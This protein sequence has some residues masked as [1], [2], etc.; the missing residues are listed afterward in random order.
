MVM[1]EQGERA[2]V[3]VIGVSIPRS[4]HN[5]AVRLL[6]AAIPDD[7]FYCEYYGVPGCCQA[8]PCARR[9]T[10]P[11]TF[12]KSHDFDL[13]LPTDLPG[14]HY[15]AMYR[16][17][18]PAILSNREL[19][20]EEYGDEVASNRDEYAV[21]LGRNAE[22]Y[23]TFYERWIRTFAPNKTVVDYDE[24]AARPGEVIQRLLERIGR[25]ADATAVEQA[26]IAT[27]P[28]GGLFGERPYVP[29][30]IETSTYLDR[31][32]I[33]RFESIV[34]YHLPRLESRR[35]LE[36]IEFH[37]TVTWL[38]FAA[39]RASRSGD[40]A[41]ARQHFQAATELEPE[42]ASLRYEHA[43]VLL[44]ED[45][46]LEAQR[47]LT[48]AA[49]RFPTHRPILDALATA[50]LAA[51]DATSA[52]APM[53]ALAAATPT[54]VHQLRLVLATTHAGD[55]HAGSELLEQVARERPDDAAAWRL[56]AEIW[57]TRGNVQQALAALDTAVRLAPLQGDLYV[58]RG[59]ILRDAGQPGAAAV[60]LREALAIDA[61][62]PR[63][64]KALIG[65]YLASGDRPGARRA[66]DEARG[67]FPFDTDF[68]TMLGEVARQRERQPD[69][70]PR[71]RVTI[72]GRPMTSAG[73]RR[74]GTTP[75]T[76]RG[77]R[78]QPGGSVSSAPGDVAH[79][80]VQ[81]SQ[82]RVALGAAERRQS[83]T[84]VTKQRQL[85]AAW[86]EATRLSGSLHEL[87]A[88][89]K[90]QALELQDAWR[91]AHLGWDRAHAGWEQAQS[92]A[93]ELQRMGQAAEAAWEQARLL[94]RELRA[95]G[96]RQA[97]TAA[98]GE[99]HEMMRLR[100]TTAL[101]Q[102]PALLA[103]ACD[104]SATVAEV[105]A[106]FLLGFVALQNDLAQ[107]LGMDVSKALDAAD[108]EVRSLL[109]RFIDPIAADA[110]TGAASDEGVA[111]STTDDS[112]A[113]AEGSRHA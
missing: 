37:S 69:A 27:T 66:I 45:R 80:Q 5:F 64:W 84:E 54:L 110:V 112:D 77:R 61:G 36:P 10:Q 16:S 25:T 100:L 59:Q 86:D 13:N 29:R 95:N 56:M 65:A 15:L 74:P 6:Q 2:P 91:E 92:V 93:D 17:P 50:S 38:V 40:L 89:F 103:R 107:D 73:R 83:E 82:L 108:D 12:Q 78:G 18:V 48:L 81:L 96:A 111:G 87:D 60:A 113:L 99:L 33:A 75:G 14:V 98:W 4:G 76:R 101:E 41:L 68:H 71:R 20:A 11:I 1:P 70:T 34:L 24:I 94:D 39:L 19:Y 102:V 23:V 55:E 21:W 51:G 52:L 26:V 9:G 90:Q 88:A 35:V 31:E 109:E 62:H 85:E 7:L 49:E 28:H 22:Y 44:K 46:F 79:L 43:V 30:S 32:L 53:A 106:K 72:G 42:N 104:G 3:H 105:H 97:A 63:W 8:V 67:R 47:E 57:H 58:Q